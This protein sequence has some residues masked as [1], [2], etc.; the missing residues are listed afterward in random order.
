MVFEDDGGRK[1]L[2][3]ELAGKQVQVTDIGIFT[4]PKG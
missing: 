3:D 1:Y 4:V 2:I